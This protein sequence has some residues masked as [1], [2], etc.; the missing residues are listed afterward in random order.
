MF[1]VKGL[2]GRTGVIQNNERDI[3]IIIIAGR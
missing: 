3:Y 1:T 2:S